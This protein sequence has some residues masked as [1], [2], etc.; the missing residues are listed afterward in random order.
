MTV[1]DPTTLTPPELA[2]MLRTSAE[3][4]PSQEAAANLVISH[5][6]WL[7]RPDFLRDCVVAVDHGMHYGTRV[8]MAAISWQR[9]AAFLEQAP[10]SRT[11]TAVLRLACS[12]GGVDTGALGDLTAG[13]DPANTARV[14]DAV[15]HGASWHRQGFRYTV[16]GH[17]DRDVHDRTRGLTW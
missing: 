5:G 9:T 4:V 6:V 2:P 12:I 17:Q 1:L 10:A 3:G 13:L 7:R 15:A 11:E 16:D 8:P 14:L